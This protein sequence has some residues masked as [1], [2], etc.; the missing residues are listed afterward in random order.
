MVFSVVMHD[1]IVVW[2]PLALYTQA[3]DLCIKCKIYMLTYLPS[4]RQVCIPKYDHFV[5]PRI[6]FEIIFIIPSASDAAIYG[7]QQ[8]FK[9][10][11]RDSHWLISSWKRFGARMKHVFTTTS[12]IKIPDY[13]FLQKSWASSTSVISVLTFIS[14]W[15][16]K[17]GLWNL[18]WFV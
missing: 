12:Y 9:S 8:H 2:K 14:F 3:W 6:I 17:L 1:T 13:F 5:V 10:N 16:Q 4:G 18:F 7:D 11:S 15:W